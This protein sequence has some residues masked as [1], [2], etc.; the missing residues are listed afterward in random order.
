MNKVIL[1][2]LLLLLGCDY[3]GMRGQQGAPGVSAP[4][5][6][7]Q[8]QDYAT[9]SCP[10]GT[11]VIIH[12]GTQGPTG[13]G[14]APGNPGTVITVVNLCPG[15]TIYPGVFVEVALR[16]NNALY[17]VYS[18]NNGFLTQLVPGNYSSNA[19]GSACNFTVNPD[20]SISH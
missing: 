13:P 2:S 5:T 1:I 19:V 12:N 4:C 6:V 11:T 8:G 9:I 10:D 14:G 17:A 18:I 16:I 15:I 20:L 7:S 3:S